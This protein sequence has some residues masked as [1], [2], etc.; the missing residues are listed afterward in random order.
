MTSQNPLF[1]QV[2]KALGAIWLAVA[3]LALLFA[4]WRFVGDD[5][6]L[7]SFFLLLVGGVL[8]LIMGSWMVIELAGRKLIAL[9]MSFIVGFREYML[10]AHNFPETIDVWVARSALVLLLAVITFVFYAFSRIKQ[11]APQTNS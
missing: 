9:V 2:E 5:I 10:W 1:R 4:V 6:D 7:R 11:R 8:L 3:L